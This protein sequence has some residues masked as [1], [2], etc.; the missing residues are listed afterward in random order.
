MVKVSPHEHK[1]AEILSLRLALF[2]LKMSFPNEKKR[3][4]PALE[5][6]EVL[7]FKKRF[8]STFSPKKAP[9]LR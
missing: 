1:H 9:S 5:G 7:Y 3:S 4:T 6:R 8:Q 2:G